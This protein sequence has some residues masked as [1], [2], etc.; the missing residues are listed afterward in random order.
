M[1]LLVCTNASLGNLPDGGTQGGYII[2]LANEKGKVTP[3]DP[4]RIEPG[5][6]ITYNHMD[7]RTKIS[8]KVLSKAGKATGRNKNW[9]NIQCLKPEDYEGE[10][11][12]LDLTKVSGLEL[13]TTEPTPTTNSDETLMIMDKFLLKM[14]RKKNLKAGKTI[15]CTL[16]EDNGQSCFHQM[17]LYTQTKDEVK[18]KARLVV[19]G[20]EEIGKDDNP[21]DSLKTI[22][23]IFAQKN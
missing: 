14:Q 7:T 20:V 9:Y 12:S 21:K 19:R 2:F 8:A 18:T 16:K 1:S 13:S 11:M 10:K 5:Q 3:I 17:G 4:A 22:S 6:I 23:S 15:M